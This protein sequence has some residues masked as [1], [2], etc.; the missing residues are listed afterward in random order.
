MV[1][2]L[3]GL[4][5]TSYG[6]AELANH[7]DRHIAVL[8]D[9]GAIRVDNVQLVPDAGRMGMASLGKPGQIYFSGFSSTSRPI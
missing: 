9:G 8:D 4:C 3:S 6:S 7:K 2:R 5:G 1:V